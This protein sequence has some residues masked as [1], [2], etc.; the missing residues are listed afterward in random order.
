MGERLAT[1]DVGRKVGEGCCTPFRGGSWVTG[2]D[3]TQCRLDRLRNKWH[4]DPFNRL[5]SGHSTPA[6]QTGNGPVE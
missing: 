1:I 6:L 5:A 2:P 4:P 3:L